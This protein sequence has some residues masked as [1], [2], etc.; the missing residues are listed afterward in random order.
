[1]NYA[2][3]P[4]FGSSTWA[5]NQAMRVVDVKKNTTLTINSSLQQQGGV[6]VGEVSIH[7]L[8]KYDDRKDVDVNRRIIAW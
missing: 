7:G 6:V 4:A 3:D 8:G 1:M 5:C 2:I